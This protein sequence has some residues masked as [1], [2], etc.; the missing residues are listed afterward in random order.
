M[1]LDL[2]IL[3]HGYSGNIIVKYYIHFSKMEW[4]MKDSLFQF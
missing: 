4:V 3:K 1:A 2:C